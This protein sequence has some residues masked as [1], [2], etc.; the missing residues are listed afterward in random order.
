MPVPSL[1]PLQSLG[2][3]GPRLAPGR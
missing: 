1:Q 3:P 2:R